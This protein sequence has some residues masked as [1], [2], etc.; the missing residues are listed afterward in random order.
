MTKSIFKVGDKVKYYPEDSNMAWYGTIFSVAK[1]SVKVINSDGDIEKVA[2]HL[3][4]F[5]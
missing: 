1:K 5:D 3:V 2:I 4:N